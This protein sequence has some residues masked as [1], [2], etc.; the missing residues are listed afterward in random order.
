MLIQGK[1]TVATL[2]PSNGDRFT[3]TGTPDR[4]QVQRETE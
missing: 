4:L 2:H 3:I 1:E